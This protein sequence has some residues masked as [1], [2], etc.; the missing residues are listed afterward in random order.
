MDTKRS[1]DSGD[2]AGPPG[3]VATIARAIATAVDPG[4]GLTLAQISLLGAVY[5][6][7]RAADIDF[8]NLEPLGPEE[9]AV[10]LAGRDPL[11]RRRVVH[12]M[13]L[14]ELIL[15]PIPPPVARRVSEYAAALG[16]DDPYVRV[17][18]RYAQGAF[19]LAWLDLHHSG[20]AEHWDRARKDQLRTSV[21]LEHQLAAGV[22]D[23]DLAERWLAFADLGPQTLGRQVWDMYR[24]R[25]FGLPGST[26]GASPYLA[27]HDFVHV[28]ADYGTNLQGELE[29]FALIGRADP[30]PKGFA[31]LTTLVGLFE[32][33][34]VA[35]AGFF[36]CDVTE[37]RLD[38]PAMHRRLADALLRGRHLSD[39]LA[40]DL[41]EIDYHELAD[42]SVEQV[43]SVLGIA[44]KSRVAV[45][46]GSPGVVE[47]AGMSPVQREYAARLADAD[48]EGKDR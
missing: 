7:V 28:L 5:A 9:L 10:A 31:W 3:E 30:D 4:G 18:R 11:F 47:P 8:S 34:Y 12:D 37:H 43:R 13:V 42:R 22:E 38:S 20:F 24:G 48:A 35:D 25:G 23:R 45:Q 17:A 39:R 1:V 14:G 26:G 40:V 46:S 33:G 27:Q 19:G 2:V 21:A 44:P 16:I 6:A 36:V 29:V 41:L 32:T 15:R